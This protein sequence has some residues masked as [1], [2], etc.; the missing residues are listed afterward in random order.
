MKKKRAKP[1]PMFS[2]R[3]CPQHTFVIMTSEEL[4]I[5]LRNVGIV[6]AF[7]Q[8]LQQLPC[9]LLWWRDY[10][11]RNPDLCQC[12]IRIR[13]CSDVILPIP[14]QKFEAS[15]ACEWSFDTNQP[16]PQLPNGYSPNLRMKHKL[17]HWLWHTF[18]HC[19]HI[20]T[21][22]TLRS[23]HLHLQPSRRMG[24]RHN[25]GQTLFRLSLYEGF[26]PYDLLHHILHS[27]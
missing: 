22:G 2:F 15:Q 3:L 4:N 14:I 20:A 21:N 6:S 5:S 25:F 9:S 11:D 16:P 1:K 7:Q 13:L 26:L 17:E 24:L 18:Y 8:F 10:T 19:L 23:L 12:P 27:S